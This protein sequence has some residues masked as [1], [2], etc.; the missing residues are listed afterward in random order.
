MDIYSK[1]VKKFEINTVEDLE[2]FIKDSG[3]KKHFIKFPI[4]KYATIEY[5]IHTTPKIN[6]GKLKRDFIKKYFTIGTCINAL[7]WVERGYIYDE[8]IRR[9]KDIQRNRGNEFH[10]NRRKNPKI[11]DGYN[12]TQKS[13]WIKR[14][15]SHDEAI[16]I[17]SKR[18]S[19]FSKQKLIDE[20][21]EKIA[22]ELLAKRNQKWFDS[23]KKNNDW[24]DLSIKKGRNGLNQIKT[25]SKHIE[26]YGNLYGRIKF[27][28][29][30]WGIDIQTIDEFEK[31]ESFLSKERTTL[32]YDKNYRELILN[33]QYCKCGECGIS[34][35]DAKFHLHHIDY[36]K[37][38]DERTNLIFLCHSCHSKTTNS[39]RDK[40]IN[41]YTLKNKKYYD[42]KI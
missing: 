39:N 13:Y 33:E 23:L 11:Y 15:Y 25:L 28:K 27:A 40:W 2:K 5:D 41:Y 4:E 14:G 17:I 35:T 32:F 3:V 26:Y 6:L 1:K 38:N 12:P 20:F 31:Y 19:T 8:A 18:Q 37:L 16:E 10:K 29:R 22:L 9:V 7:Y 42:K 21:G 36:N 24:Y 30:Y 34:N